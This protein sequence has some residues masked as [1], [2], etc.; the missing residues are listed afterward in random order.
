MKILES[1][2]PKLTDL[3]ALAKLYNI[4][5]QVSLSFPIHEEPP[6]PPALV[7]QATAKTVL[8]ALNRLRAAPGQPN[9]ELV[10]KFLWARSWIA[11]NA[12]PESWNLERVPVTKEELQMIASQVAQFEV[13]AKSPSHV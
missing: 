4:D 5:V 8:W 3:F 9:R 10:R 11:G 13:D 12:E 2:L 6:P 1:D 7:P